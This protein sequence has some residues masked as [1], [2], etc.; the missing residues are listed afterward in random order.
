MKSIKINTIC[1]V[2]PGGCAVEAEV[3]DGTLIGLKPNKTARF[4]SICARGTAASEVVYSPD[5][6]KKPLMRT[7]ERGEGKF[8]E[9]EWDEAL[10][11]I[12][13]KMKKLKREYGA[14]C[15]MSHSGRGVFECS[16]SEFNERYGTKLLW[17]FGSPNVSTVGSIC[18]QSFG[19]L[20]PM[21][22]YGLMGPCLIPDFQNTNLIIVWGSNPITDSPPFAFHEI[23]KAK[24]QGKKIITIDHMKSDM[25]NRSDEWIP[26]RSGTDGALALGLINIIIKEKLYDEEFVDKWTIGFEELKLYVSQFTPEEVERITKVPKD[27][28][29][30]L[31]REISMANNAT[32]RTFTG[33]EYT[34]SGV[35]NIRAV[36]ILWALTG[37]VDVPGGIYLQPN[38][39]LLTNNE[40]SRIPKGIKAIG[41]DEYPVFNELTSIAHFMEFP[42]SV[43]EGKPYKTRGLLNI[44]SSIL[45]SYPQPDIYEEAFK[46]LDLMVTID[47]FMTK[48]ALYADVVL[49]AT[50]H[51]EIDS[52]Q[53]YPGYARLRRKVI[54]PIGESRNDMLIFAGLANRLG[55]GHLY[56]Q[57]E[58]EIVERAFS[59]NQELLRKLKQSPDGVEI[60][61]IERNYKKYELGLLRTDRKPGFPTES[62][63][64][65]IYSKYLQEHGYNPLPEY[66]EPTEGPLQSPELYKQYPL[67]L[68]TGARISSTFRS[69]HLNIPSL[70]KMQDKPMVLINPYDAKIRNISDG[71]RVKV[72]TK[73]GEVYFYADVSD[74][75]ELGTVEVNQGGGN[76]IQVKAWREAN[77]NYLTDF[78]NRDSISGFPVLKAL[79]CEVEK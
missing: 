57:T 50:T 24:K 67:V 15:I 25:A 69:Q 37:N 32:I 18:Y 53:R 56:P 71:N 11:Y 61:T 51:F 3:K 43:L 48:D 52:Y 5:R 39:N 35:Q 73:H 17:E 46:E 72:I 22:T 4:G 79:L 70:L 68:N 29:G 10:D 2:C 9:A 65:E 36:Y 74:K 23:M 13:D 33:L 62:G 7:G 54:E 8:R 75:I 20:A 28:V 6:L 19:T 26:I 47:R 63:K 44:G 27:K 78:R 41:A 66:I 55:F 16:F 45:T 12:A 76:P 49:P 30:W 21:T 1:G 14:E 34:N 59:D 42:K 60:H 64:L 31:A 38:L 77:V 58:E 40:S